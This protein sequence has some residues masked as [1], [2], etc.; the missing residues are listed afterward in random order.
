MT[1]SISSLKRKEPSQ[2]E[3]AGDGQRDGHRLHAGGQQ[4]H[5]DHGP[6]ADGALDGGGQAVVVAGGLDDDVGLARRRSP[7]ASA[8]LRTS[9]APTAWAIS[10]GLVVQVDG[11]DP[12][13]AGTLE[14]G[15]GQRADGAG[16]DH[17]RGLP[18]TSPARETACQA[19]LAGSISAAVRRSMPAGRGRSIRAGRVDVPA[20]GAVGVRV[21]RRAAQVGAA[22]RQ[23]GP[24]RRVLGGAGAGRGGVHRDGG[25]GCRAR[26][27]RRPPDHGAGR[28]RGPAPAAPSGWTP[29]PRRAAS[30][31]GRSRRC[32]RSATS[33]TAS[34]GR[35][36]G[37]RDVVDPQV[38][39][40][41]GHHGRAGGRECCGASSRP[42]DHHRHSAVDEDGLSVDEVRAIGGQPHRGSGQVLRRCPSGGPGSGPGSRS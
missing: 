35:G 33:T 21:A 7:S 9:S 13:G 1:S 37:Q 20:E 15:D 10:S 18:G 38:A 11:D 30:S 14:D 36:R 3:F 16:A 27:R 19:T 2:L 26:C 4:A 32:R 28:S 42:S 39:G 29:P 12:G 5:H 40:G 31:A 17:Q 25:P 8:A 23:V 24:V 41:V 6:A 34:S 22:G